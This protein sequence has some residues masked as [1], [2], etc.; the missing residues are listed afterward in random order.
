MTV[1]AEGAR[2]PVNQ[3]P[4]AGLRVLVVEDH[5]DS[6]YVIVKMLEVAGASVVGVPS[7]DHALRMIDVMQPD[8]LVSDI[9][10]PGRD[11]LSLIRE[12]RSNPG[13][14]LPAVAVTAR[15]SPADRRLILAAGFQAHVPK[16]IDFDQLVQVI[17]HVGIASGAGAE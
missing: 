13:H 6:R 17:R 1:A 3:E 8:V 11:G 5:D 10:M 15:V 12:L 14:R 16:P 2:R 7:V 4:L 9:N